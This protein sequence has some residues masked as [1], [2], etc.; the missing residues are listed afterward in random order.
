VQEERVLRF[1]TDVR[2]I[3]EVIADVAAGHCPVGEYER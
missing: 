1:L 3:A 2:R